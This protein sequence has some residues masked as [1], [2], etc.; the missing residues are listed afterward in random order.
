MPALPTPPSTLSPKLT[1]TCCGAGAL[2]AIART[3]RP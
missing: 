1:L 3:L 2:P